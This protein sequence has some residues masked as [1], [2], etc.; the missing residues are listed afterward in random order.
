MTRHCHDC[1]TEYTLRGQP[2][3]SEACPCGADL[4]VCLNCGSYEPRVA[5]QCRDPRAE[6]VAEKH[7]ATYCEYFEFARRVWTPKAGSRSRE[8]AARAQLR[9]LFGD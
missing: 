2:G 9:K 6:P 5:Q 3:R 1:G 8:E 4:R 7:V